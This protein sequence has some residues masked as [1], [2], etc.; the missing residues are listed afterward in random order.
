MEFTTRRC[1]VKKFIPEYISIM[2]DGWGTDKDVGM[3]LL[4]YKENMSLD[5]FKAF[6][7][8]TYKPDYNDISVIQE[9]STSNIIGYINLYQEDSRSK[10]V[11]I[12]IHKSSWNK[13]YGREV[14]QELADIEKK[15]GLGSLYA[16][17]DEHNYAAQKILDAT[18]FE[19][20]DNLPG[21]RMSLD[22]RVGDEYLYEL[23]MIRVHYDT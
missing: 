2:Y 15:N 23:E 14:L 4:G 13:Q 3:F 8:N 18:G 5:E 17:C 7:L 19:L 16:T 20:I 12:V 22:G 6:I 9:K 1:I 11:I 10:S 21:E